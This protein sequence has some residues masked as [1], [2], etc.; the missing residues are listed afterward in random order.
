MASYVEVTAPAGAGEQETARLDLLP[1]GRV[2][3]TCGTGPTGQGH[4][5]A[6]AMLAAERLGVAVTDVEVVHGDTDR[7]G[8]GTG[9]WGSRSL[10]VGGSAVDKA[11]VELVDVA[12]HRVADEIGVPVYDVQLVDGL[13]TGGGE[14]RSWSEVAGEDGFGHETSFTAVGSTYPF[15]A[16]V[17]VVEVDTETGAVSLRSITAV[18]DAGRILNPV[19]V[20]GQRHGGLAQGIAQALFE[21][22]RYDP[23]GNPLTATFLDYGLP[24]AAELPSFDLVGHSRTLEGIIVPRIWR[25]DIPFRG[26]VT[27]PSP[28]TR[29]GP[30][31]LR[32]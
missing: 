19:L 16:H 18:D 20:E 15:G 29:S 12:R 2:R 26:G 1:G 7:L 13:F 22:M 25:R 24:S 32:G 14:R 21:E 6:W 11:A 4:A 8:S 23:D 9:T 10:Q 17:A 5:T 3:V 30:G 27:S 31:S 28:G